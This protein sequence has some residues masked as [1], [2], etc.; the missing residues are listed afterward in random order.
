MSRA[1]FCVAEPNGD[2]AKELDQRILQNKRTGASSSYR[3]AALI[4]DTS[5]DNDL[6]DRD[7]TGRSVPLTRTE[8]TRKS[9]WLT[10]N[11]WKSPDEPDDSYK[12]QRRRSRAVLYQLS[13][14]YGNKKSAK[15]KL[16]LN[17]VSVFAGS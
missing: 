5:D 8:S 2:A 15:S 17:K 12:Y 4:Q 6:S 16:Q 1:S 9:P 11:S 7:D 10:G 13:G 14:S 3:T